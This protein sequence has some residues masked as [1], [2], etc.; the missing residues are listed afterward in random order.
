[1]QAALPRAHVDAENSTTLNWMLIAFAFVMVLGALF[2]WAW[3]PE[4]QYSRKA[5][6]LDDGGEGEVGEKEEEERRQRERCTGN[7]IPSMTL[8]TLAEGRMGVESAKRVGLRTNLKKAWRK[9]R[10]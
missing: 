1:V 7:K 9:L 4:V 5:A 6:V 10:R 2:A 8:E 3:I